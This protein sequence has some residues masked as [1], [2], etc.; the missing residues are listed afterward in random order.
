MK[1][2]L[3]TKP[4]C[5]KSDVKCA[6]LYLQIRG[7]GVWKPHVAGEG[8][9]DQVPQLDAVGWDDVAEAIMVVAKEFWEV[10]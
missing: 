7:E 9:E 3:H 1:S 10:M 6:T 5:I 4:Q 8:T 2:Q